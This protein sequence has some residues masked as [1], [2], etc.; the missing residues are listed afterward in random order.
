MARAMVDRDETLAS[1]PMDVVA[2][3]GRVAA[4]LTDRKHDD[5]PDQLVHRF[6]HRVFHHSRGKRLVSVPKKD[7]RVSRSFVS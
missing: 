3:K 2:W 7:H 5:H 1:L 4:R 6:E